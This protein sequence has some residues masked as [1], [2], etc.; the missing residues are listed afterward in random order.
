MTDITIRHSETHDV[1]TIRRIAAQPAVYM[2]TLQ[3]PFP[4]HEKWLQRL[5]RLREH[6]VS[7]VAEIDGAVVGHLALHPEQ[8]P[9]RRHAASLGMMVDASHH[10]RGIGSRLLAAAIDLAENWLNITR[11]EL[12]VFVDNSAAIA[13]YEKHGFRIE[14]E[15]PD[16]ALR[17][18]AYAS[19]FQM[20][21]INGRQ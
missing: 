20:A 12:T 9:R 21:R 4:S 1:D 8:N 19:V 3:H 16:Y 6:G 5:E 11:V 7:L 15:A 17:D 18:G 10:G 14:G 13:L 2:N